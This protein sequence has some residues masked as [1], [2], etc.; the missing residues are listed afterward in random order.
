MPYG[1]IVD[2]NYDRGFG[3]ISNDGGG[4]NQ[5]VHIS[6]CPGKV[7]PAVGEPFAYAIEVDHISGRE[8]AVDLEPLGAAR[9]ECDRVFGRTDGD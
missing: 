5:F 6:Q 8:K 7:A 4:R 3:F 1:K 9:E 2:F